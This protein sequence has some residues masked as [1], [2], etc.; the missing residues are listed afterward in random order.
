MLEKG[1]NNSVVKEESPSTEPLDPL[2]P[3]SV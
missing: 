3:L 2:V 1:I